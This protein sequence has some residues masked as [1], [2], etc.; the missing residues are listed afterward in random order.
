MSGHHFM[1]YRKMGVRN[2]ISRHGGNAHHQGENQAIRKIMKW[3]VNIIVKKS[4]MF[5]ICNKAV[6]FRYFC[7]RILGHRRACLQYALACGV[8]IKEIKV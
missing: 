2:Y 6:T 3:A 7:R 5:I 1:R 8:R 4:E